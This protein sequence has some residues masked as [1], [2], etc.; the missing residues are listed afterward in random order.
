MPTTLDDLGWSPFFDDQLA[1]KDRARGRPAR[2]VEAFRKRCLVHTGEGG[3]QWATA[4]GSMFHRARDRVDLPAVGDWFVVESIEEG[5]SLRLWRRLDRRTQIVRTAAGGRTVPQVIAANV[6]TLLIVTSLN[7]EFSLRRLERYIQLAE[8]GSVEPVVILNKADLIAPEALDALT[9]RVRALTEQSQI[10]VMTTSAVAPIGHDALHALATPGTTLALAGSSGVGKSTLVNLLH[11]SSIQ[12]TAAVRETDDRGRH[13]T[14]SRQL[15][16][17]PSGA[18]IID[19]PGIRELQLWQDQED[20]SMAFAAIE[21]LAPS[22]HFRDCAHDSERG[23][24]V[25]E[26]VAS[27]EIDPAQLDAWRKLR[28]EQQE[29]ARR[30]QEID[31]KRRK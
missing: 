7:Q 17:L 31:R 2:V 10:K 13:T 29:R 25:Q 18:M 8:S 4:R 30:Q 5:N 21:A 24:G 12:S 14:T 16:V 26:A 9:T 20:A 3:V 28:Q 23:C 19:T 1:D 27:G 11:G 15:V 22:C 6:D